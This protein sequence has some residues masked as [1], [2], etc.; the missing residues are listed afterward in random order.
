M[1][2]PA[3]QLELVGSEG[4]CL[5]GTGNAAVLGPCTGDG[6]TLFYHDKLTGRIQPTNMSNKCLDV[7]ENAAGGPPWPKASVEN[8][9]AP[10]ASAA[11]QNQQYQFNP[12][13]GA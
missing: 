1:R 3:G 7:M 12:Q 13:T 6:S 9:C 5:S 11:A 8:A 2:K 4:L 10:I